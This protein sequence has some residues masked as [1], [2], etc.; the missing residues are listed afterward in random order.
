MRAGDWSNPAMTTAAS[1]AAPWNVRPCRK[2]VINAQEAERVRLIFGRYLALGCVA[3]LQADLD[4]RGVRSKQRVLTSGRVLGGCSFGRGAL[5]HL[6]KNRIYRGEVVHNGIV[7][8]G[9]HKAIVEEEPWTAV[10]A[11]LADNCSTRRK[12]RVETGALL[13][14]L[15]YDDRG[16]IM[17]PTYS[18]RRGNRYRYYLS[19]ALLHDR[20]AS[21]S[22]RARVNA[23]DVEQLV[24]ELLSRELSRPA[25]SAG[26]PSAGWST[27]TRT[28]VRDAVEQVVVNGGQVQ[29]VRKPAAPSATPARDEDG[30]APQVLVAPLPDPRPR[31]RKEIIVPGGHNSSPRRLNHVLILAI[32]RAKSW[33][34]DLRSGKYAD[35]TEIARQFQL[36]DAHVRRILR[37]GYL[38]PDIVEAIIEGRQPRSM[39][40]KRLLQGIPCV[41]A[42]QR[43]AFGFAR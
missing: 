4:Q 32:A 13:G 24:V 33:M 16:N 42:D 31:A 26:G 9:A 17:S 22:W 28:V 27:E 14:G 12:S 36:N 15:I 38:A 6:L 7:Y 2:L 39:T 18:V 30:D 29:V 23:D 3:K 41:W 5:Y 25:L 10:Q 35:T 20:K 43:A 40:V 11:R 8:P 37:F 34:R 19:S 1:P 21:A